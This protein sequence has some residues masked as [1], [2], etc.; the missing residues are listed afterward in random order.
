[1]VELAVM[2]FMGLDLS[3]MN[4]VMS[5]V[6]KY[7]SLLILSFRRERNSVSLDTPN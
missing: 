6:F 1:M 2:I 7:H 5:V 4:D 3:E